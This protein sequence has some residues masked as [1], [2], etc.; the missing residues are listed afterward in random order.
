MLYSVEWK[1]DLST[2]VYDIRRC[3]QPHVRP[4][5]PAVAEKHGKHTV[6]MA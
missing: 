3:K 4:Y 2:K 1:V 6:S 5:L